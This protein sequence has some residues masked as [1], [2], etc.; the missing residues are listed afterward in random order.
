MQIL[1]Q[2]NSWTQPTA[3][4][5]PVVPASKSSHITL[6]SNY[7]QIIYYIK[8][9]IIG[10]YFYTITDNT[11]LVTSSFWSAMDLGDLAHSTFMTFLEDPKILCAT[12][13]DRR[14]VNDFIKKANMKL[15]LSQRL[16]EHCTQLL[17]DTEV[18]LSRMEPDKFGANYTSLACRATN[19][20]TASHL[21]YRYQLVLMRDMVRAK[22]RLGLSMGQGALTDLAD[23]VV[24]LRLDAP[25]VHDM[26]VTT[27]NMQDVVPTS[28]SDEPPLS[29]LWRPTD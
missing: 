16:Q 21:I 23:R 26:F 28:D 4:P 22:E 9:Y 17:Y 14:R 11:W 29:F 20:Q 24:S 1:F 15:A 8:F 5:D 19:Y 13:A 6:I 12:L 2:I 18:K 25:N 10:T 3:S 27:N 7:I